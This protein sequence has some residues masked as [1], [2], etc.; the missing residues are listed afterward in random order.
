MKNVHDEMKECQKISAITKRLNKTLDKEFKEI[1]EIK[2]DKTA[3]EE[4]H[5]DLSIIVDKI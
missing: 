3:F 5:E 1:R 4:K 2:M